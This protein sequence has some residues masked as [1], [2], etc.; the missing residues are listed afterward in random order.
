MPHLEKT[1]E[2]IVT[3]RRLS[4][5]PALPD[6][7]SCPSSGEGKRM[8]KD[9]MIFEDDSGEEKDG[10][11]NVR[12][13]RRGL[14]M[15]AH[16]ALPGARDTSAAVEEEV[17]TCLKLGNLIIFIREYTDRS[18]INMDSLFFGISRE[19]VNASALTC[20]QTMCHRTWLIH[21]V[22]FLWILS[23]LYNDL[24][25]L[26]SKLVLRKKYKK[27]LGF[28]CLGS[29]AEKEAAVYSVLEE[30]VGRL[31]EVAGS[32]ITCGPVLNWLELDNRG[33]R[34]IV[35]DDS[36]INTPA[37]AA[38]YV[39]KRY[40]A[41][42]SDE[43]SFEV[44][45][46]ISVIDMPPPEE[47]IWWRGKRGFQVGFFPCECVQVIGDKV[48]QTIQP[49]SLTLPPARSVGGGGIG[50]YHHTLVPDTRHPTKPVL[51][52]HGKLIAFFRSFIL[53][54]P[55]RRKL[56][57]SGILKERV[58]GCDLGEHLLNSGH[59][60]PMVLRCCAEF[61]ESHGII[62]GIYRLS[63]ITSNI[64]KLRNTFDEDRVPD[65][66]TDESIV[67]DIHCVS[68]VLK[69]YF[70]ELPNPLLT[71]QLYDKFVAA[72]MQEEDLRL[73]YVR[74]VVQQLPPPHYR[75]LEYLVQHLS[76]VASHSHGTSMTPKNIAIVWAPNLLRSKNLDM[77]GVAALQDVGT[78]AVVTEYLV[79]YVDLIFNDKIPTTLPTLSPLLTTNNGTNED[80]SPRKTAR[81]K[82]L[83]IC[84]PTKLLSLDEARS[85][86]AFTTAIKPDQSYIE[87]GGGPQNLPPKY[88]T[89]IELPNRKGG[90]LKH[91]KSPLGWKN[92]FSKGRSL[93]KHQRKASTPTDIHLNV[94]GSS[95]PELE[96]APTSSKRLRPGKSLESL[97][98]SAVSMPSNRI[99]QSL[100]SP[101]KDNSSDLQDLQEKMERESRR[102]YEDGESRS[103]CKSSPIPSPR[104][105]SRSI[106]HDSYFNTLERRSQTLPSEGAVT[107]EGES[108]FDLSPDGSSS[109]IFLDISELNIDFGTSEKD[110]KIFS[111]DDTLRSTSAEDPES[112]SLRSHI[113]M[114][115]EGEKS[116]DSISPR[117]EKKTLKDKIKRFTSP[118]SQR[119]NE[120]S[121]VSDSSEDSRN[122]SLKRASTAIKEKIVH[123]L[124]PETCRRQAETTQRPSS[125]CSSPKIKHVRTTETHSTIDVINNDSDL[126]LDKSIEMVTAEVHMDPYSTESLDTPSRHSMESALIDPELLEKITHLRTSPSISE[127]KMSC[128]SYTDA[129]ASDN[130][131]IN[132]EH[133]DSCAEQNHFFINIEENTNKNTPFL[134]NASSPKN[135]EPQNGRCVMSR[136][137]PGESESQEQ[138]VRPNSLLGLPIPDGHNQGSALTSPETPIEDSTFLEI[139]YHPLSDTTEP[140]TPSE[141]QFCP[142]DISL[143]DSGMV[144]NMCDIPRPSSPLSI[145]LSSSDE[146]PGEA[147]AHL[148]ENIAIFNSMERPQK[149][150]SSSFDD[151]EGA[152]ET[153]T[154]Q[155]S[156]DSD[157]IT[158]C[159]D[160]IL[161]GS[162]R[163][164]ENVEMEGEFRVTCY[165]NVEFNSE[166]QN[167]DFNTKKSTS[168]TKSVK[169]SSP[170]E[171]SENS[172]SKNLDDQV[173]KVFEICYED[174]EVPKGKLNYSLHKEKC[175]E[176]SYESNDFDASA[177]YENVDNESEN[178]FLPEYKMTL[179]E[180]E[181]ENVEFRH[182]QPCNVHNKKDS[183]KKESK[184]QKDGEDLYEQVKF[185]K[186]SIKEVNE[187][188]VPDEHMISNR[189][190]NELEIARE[191][192]ENTTQVLSNTL[193]NDNQAELPKQVP[194]KDDSILEFNVDL[195]TSSTVSPVGSPGLPRSVADVTLTSE[196]SE[197]LDSPVTHSSTSMATEVLVLPAFASPTESSTDVTSPASSDGT[198]SP[199]NLEDSP[200]TVPSSP[201][202]EQESEVFSKQHY[203]SSPNTMPSVL[204]SLTPPTPEPL[205]PPAATSTPARTLSNILTPT[206]W[207]RK[208]SQHSSINVPLSRPN[209]LPTLNPTS[210]VSSPSSVSP[211]SPASN[212]TSNSTTSPDESP[213]QQS[214]ELPKPVDQPSQY[215]YEYSNK[216]IEPSQA[217]CIEE[218][219]SSVLPQQLPPLPPYTILESHTLPEPLSQQ[220][221]VSE[222]NEFQSIDTIA[223][224]SFQSK[225]KSSQAHPPLQ[226]HNTSPDFR[227]PSE[228]EIT[229]VETQEKGESEED[230][231]K[232]ERIEKYKE[233]RR[234]V[235]REKFKSESFRGE[236]DELITRLKEKATSPSRLKDGELVDD[237][238]DDDDD[239]FKRPDECPPSPKR[240]MSSPTK[241][242]INKTETNEEDVHI[243]NFKR[244]SPTRRSMGDMGRAE[245]KSPTR[246]RFSSESPTPVFE[247]STSTAS[248]SSSTSGNNNSSSSSSRQGSLSNSPHSSIKRTTE[249]EQGEMEAKSSLTGKITISSQVKSPV[250]EPSQVPIVTS[251]RTSGRQKKDD[252]DDINV[253]E[254][255]AIWS[256]TPPRERLDSKGEKPLLRKPEQLK[257]TSTILK[258]TEPKIVSET[259]RK[260]S[261]SGTNKEL[262]TNVR[263]NSSSSLRNDSS[264]LLRKDIET[265]PTHKA[266]INPSTRKDSISSSPRDSISPPI[267]KTSLPKVTSPTK[268]H[269]KSTSRGSDSSLTSAA[270]AAALSST[271]SNNAAIRG[272][273]GQQRKIKD[274]AAIFE[275][276]S[277]TSAKPPLLRQSSKEGKKENTW[278]Q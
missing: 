161:G 74:D 264:P 95:V 97:V 19:A 220:P 52:K 125:P 241:Q 239:D 103:S 248:T 102:K 162:D 256:Q 214:R 226:R 9:Q 151:T 118:S 17:Y 35:T 53:S 61:I 86:A 163:D 211:D 100:E 231:M 257:I 196:D 47:S 180:N 67:Q 167:I 50:P 122:N 66:Y 198:V 235:L 113:S 170:R 40:S 230:Q 55:S 262:I 70:R 179:D 275:G 259:H 120:V 238:D 110:M 150:D 208:Q 168:G 114:G 267:R 10:T 12:T 119:K 216:N 135:L 244:T 48:P 115:S 20:L 37:V 271:A 16:T 31:S 90:S 157:A 177:L 246:F 129:A 112:A 71:Y 192:T 143:G 224:S 109:R 276:D 218:V 269:V 108:D 148:Y 260:D 91:K 184:K 149:G 62:D 242:M 142:T 14:I 124:S 270:L 73:L 63:G 247:R 166:Y 127:S 5:F 176:H 199:Q 83:A 13:H 81:P 210:P 93:P 11:N 64:Q 25:F 273:S 188:I 185:L 272:N 153:P 7:K 121:V 147:A 268:S 28:V 277:P 203:V 133:A 75:T 219:K 6:P 169:D 265:S 212:C 134:V 85:R 51:R 243:R 139:K 182:Q 236:R 72:V 274:M 209:Y 136:S 206:P 69:M 250:Q 45:D 60:I 33:H 77:G 145:S 76:R 171:V 80:G 187:I 27:K 186:K 266:S 146:E 92:I 254:R 249:K 104:T 59:E 164:Y 82:S 156:L 144:G 258:K 89:V 278:I 181:Y 49:S 132:F 223:S 94:S 34:L 225:N 30:Y 117:P 261:L 131:S 96:V 128:S 252:D 205:V 137:V 138:K 202:Q 24:L 87:V 240:R 159:V 175:D 130:E 221:N 193:I 105:H 253:K 57:Q 2:T 44:G 217:S 191:V 58:F 8:S 215:S 158:P 54:R 56:K 21:V 29:L 38:A 123:A 233:E 41:Q 3:T 84:T 229:V 263:R 107:E 46:M 213:P 42:A 255:V 207:P 201:Q 200:S 173:N 101:E 88:H 194:H 4:I 140:S 174:L 99:S 65:L 78:Q 204:P 141:S 178:Q 195:A 152:L 126:D 1:E 22:M 36:D 189:K 227:S 172:E 23:R 237:D 197:C 32:L 43:I 98:S 18:A 68:S 155:L 39:V 183:K 222:K 116:K 154:E 245:L 106:S 234:S 111:E 251:C 232:R 165:E 190:S 79:R 15:T 228:C 160:D 26:D